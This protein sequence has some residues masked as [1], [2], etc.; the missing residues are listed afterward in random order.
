MRVLV[1]GSTGFV[2]RWMVD[3]L[4]AAGHVPAGGP[5]DRVEIIDADAVTSLVDRLRPD[6]VIHLAGMS[7]GPDATRHPDAAVRVNT[8]G[9]E[10]LLHALAALRLPGPVVVVGS[11]DVYG[12]PDPRDLPL[13]ET[14]PVRPTS[15][16]GR[17]KLG[18]EEAALAAA[19]AGTV[20]VAVT[21]SFN[22]TGPGQRAEF[23]APALARRVLAARDASQ[24]E[25][26]V[27]NLDVRRDFGDVRDVVRAYRLVLE[28]LADGSIPSGTVVNVATGTS[29]SIR[30]MLRT[31]ADLVGVEVEP[32]TD[33]ALV[34]AGDPPEIVGDASRLKA[35]TGW[36]PTIQM[37]QTLADL[38][39]R[40]EAG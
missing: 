9:T 21:R 20:A 33:P 32:R 37:R 11:S 34:R 26:P 22:H 31:I 16:Y 24:R 25:I 17:S 13:T 6:G 5:G 35:L 12:A 19:R 7:Y 39:A 14:A 1:T 8:G 27:G 2:G 36:Q 28:G 30:E 4:V 3:E 10:V 40:I 29:V 38:I 18:Q 15:A 23:V